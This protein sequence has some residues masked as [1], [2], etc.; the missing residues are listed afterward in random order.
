[1][2]AGFP[3]RAIV[4]VRLDPAVGGQT[5]E[6]WLRSVPAVLSAVSVTGDVDY[7]LRL[8]CGGLADLGDVL[9]RLR[10]YPGAEVESSEMVLHE[11]TGLG[12]RRHPPA[13]VG[14]RSRRAG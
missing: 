10:G 5:F 6:W 11:V 12:R 14:L 3:V 4:R 9:A 1:M 13:E 8:G 7:E 2:A